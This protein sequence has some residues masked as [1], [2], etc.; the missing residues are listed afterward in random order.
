MA[1]HTPRAPRRDGEFCWLD[2][3]T[4]QPQATSAA[5]TEA[6]GWNFRFDETYWRPATFVT[7]HEHDLGGFSDLNA[8]I[9]PAGTP[10]H[11]AVYLAVTDI[12][13]AVVTAVRDSAQII[14]PAFDAGD[15][16]RIATLLDPF[17]GAV[18]LWQRSGHQ[19]WTHPRSLPG[20]PVRL[21]HVSESATGAAA[22]YRD[23]LVVRDRSITFGP[24]AE[25]GSGERGWQVIVGG[26]GQD[27]VLTTPGG[28]RIIVETAAD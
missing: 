16:G 3:K 17:G 25:H 5:L 18:S 6:L 8:S 12:A 19:G 23:A 10:D 26:T 15:T 14:V 13:S 27:H 22:F 20:A 9:Y 11:I 7:Y 2:V 4:R 21:H 24:C 1:S 28:L